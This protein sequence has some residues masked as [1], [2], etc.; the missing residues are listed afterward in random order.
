MDIG[1]LI[2]GAVILWLMTI[3]V[4]FGLG[5]GFGAYAPVHK[6]PPRTVESDVLKWERLEV[7]IEQAQRE[8]AP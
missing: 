5:Y 1:T 8:S 6:E 4:A 7:S 2:T 3:F